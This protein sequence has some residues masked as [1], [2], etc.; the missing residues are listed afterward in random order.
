MDRNCYN[1][2]YIAVDGLDELIRDPDPSI[3]PRNFIEYELRQLS[4]SKIK[5]FTT[6]RLD[7]MQDT[8]AI[9]CDDCDHECIRY[10]HCTGCPQGREGRVDI[11]EKCRSDGKGCPKNPAHALKLVTQKNVEVTLRMPIQDLRAYV[12]SLIE[13]KM[14]I[15]R[16]EDDMSSAQRGC[17]PGSVGWECHKD[18]KLFER[19]LKAI[20][21]AARGR[22][23]LAKQYTRS[24][25]SK[26]T[27]KAIKRALADIENDRYDISA[28][29]DR[30][31]EEDMKLR[32]MGQA[33]KDNVEIAMR[34]LSIV[35]TTRRHLKYDEL[36]QALATEVGDE[37]YDP[38]G[39]LSQ[40]SIRNL[41]KGLIRID[42]DKDATV[43]L[44][45]RTLEEYFD[46]TKDTWFPKAE[47]EMAK[48]CLIYL[49]F[50]EFSKPCE[51]FEEFALKEETHP[52]ISYAV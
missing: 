33:D 1:K 39:Q 35:S 37:S 48:T 31:W 40:E 45:H 52:F 19:I 16:A 5:F 25:A 11:C 17:A 22:F 13:N 27:L 9:S 20:S 34:I 51:D 4:P 46:K 2:V 50:E 23:L 42:G 15:V 28:T 18:K 47:F 30:L 3:C 44:D 38:E 24:L 32:I 29:I 12:Q 36:I 49:S 10:Y 14:P 7:E 41:T 21:Q 8:N 6:T 26:R 43:R